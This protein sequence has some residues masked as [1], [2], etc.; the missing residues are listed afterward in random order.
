MKYVKLDDS[1]S[2]I[3]LIFISTFLVDTVSDHCSIF[4]K[5]SNRV[6]HNYNNNM[7][8]AGHP[9]KL[10]LRKSISPVGVYFTYP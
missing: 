3:S 2:Y 8:R 1:K 4:L 6:T 9:G 7:I 10:G 5:T